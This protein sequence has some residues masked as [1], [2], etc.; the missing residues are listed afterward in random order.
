[1]ERELQD[2]TREIW[3]ALVPKI[4]SLAEENGAIGLTEFLSA[5]SY[6]EVSDG[7]YIA[8]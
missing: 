6:D 5:Y 2:E 7:M 3:E 8:N 1:M 4:I